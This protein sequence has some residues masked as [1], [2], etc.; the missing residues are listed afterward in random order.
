[1]VPTNK[2]C[3]F[4]ITVGAFSCHLRRVNPRQRPLTCQGIRSLSRRSTGGIYQSARSNHHASGRILVV[5]IR[6]WTPMIFRGSYSQTAG[7]SSLTR[8]KA[9]VNFSRAV[10][11]S[12]HSALSSKASNLGL[13]YEL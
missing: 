8:A 10:A 13:L 3:L 6:L 4:H 1:M 12:A 5:R 2:K 7:A 11:E 9:L